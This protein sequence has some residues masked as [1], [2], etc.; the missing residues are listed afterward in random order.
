MGFACRLAPAGAGYFSYISLLN[1]V[2]MMGTQLYHDACMPQHHKYAAHQ[3]ALL[4]VSGGAARHTPMRAHVPRPARMWGQ[5][6]PRLAQR[7]NLLAS[8][9]GPCQALSRR[10]AGPS[11][12]QASP[13]P[14]HVQPPVRSPPPL[15]QQCLNMLQGDTRPLRRFVEARFDEIKVITESREPYLPV[16]LSAWCGR[17]CCLAP[18]LPGPQAAWHVPQPAG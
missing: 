15:P 14:S 7:P 3:I 10:R 6:L 4:Y 12:L 5:V 11:V 16:E 8:G 17:A 1:Q 2:V 9:A 18:P 13:S